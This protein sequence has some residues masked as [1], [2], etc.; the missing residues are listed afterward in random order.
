MIYITR[1]IFKD[2]KLPS[3]ASIT[4]NYYKTANSL[5]SSELNQG[6]IVR[7]TTSNKSIEANILRDVIRSWQVKYARSML[8]ECST[9]NKVFP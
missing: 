2:F 1:V 5:P 9:S 4:I 8:T 3:V 6:E 7:L